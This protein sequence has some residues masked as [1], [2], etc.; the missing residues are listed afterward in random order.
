MAHTW[1]SGEDDL[2][3]YLR[4]IETEFRPPLAAAAT[5]SPLIVGEWCLNTSA[6]RITT[7]NQSTRR[8]YYRRIAEAQLNAWEVTVGWFYWSY[9]LQVSGPELDGWDFGKSV[10]LDYLPTEQFAPPLP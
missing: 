7:E 3:G 5:H 6:E 8:D 10:A 9:K 1:I 2:D 4:Y